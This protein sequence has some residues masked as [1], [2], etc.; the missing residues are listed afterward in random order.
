LAQGAVPARLSAVR[1][2]I[3]GQDR[4]LQAQPLRHTYS[5]YFSLVLE[6]AVLTFCNLL[7]T[8]SHQC[9]VNGYKTLH[10]WHFWHSGLP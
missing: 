1:P 10:F 8:V 3:Q 5:M 7:G 4:Q 2:D 9:S 6:E